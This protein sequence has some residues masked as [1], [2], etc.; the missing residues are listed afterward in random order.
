[1][2]IG[3]RLHGIE[4]TLLGRL[5]RSW[6]SSAGDGSG[7]LAGEPEAAHHAR[8]R[9]RA[10]ALVEA[11]LD[12]AAQIGQGPGAGLTLLGIRPAQDKVDGTAC[13]ASLSRSRR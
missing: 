5:R 13:S 11:L 4:Q 3:G 9:L 1:M 2:S 10:H 6:G 7:L 12:E 8:H